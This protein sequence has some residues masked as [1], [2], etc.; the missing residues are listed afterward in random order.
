MGPS[1]W[2]H[3]VWGL[4]LEIDTRG[5]PIG[6]AAWQTL[7]KTCHVIIFRSVGHSAFCS[8]AD[9]NEMK[10]KSEEDAHEMPSQLLFNQ[11]AK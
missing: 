4:A 1:A 10:S 8:G 3:P 7:S 11:I 2:A 6:R 5:I 9:L